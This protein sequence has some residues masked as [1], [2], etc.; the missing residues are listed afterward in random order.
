MVTLLSKSMKK[1]TFRGIHILRCGIELGGRLVMR[2]NPK[3]W[4]GSSVVICWPKGLKKGGV[5]IFK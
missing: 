3:L 1:L 4:Y 2:Y 5:D